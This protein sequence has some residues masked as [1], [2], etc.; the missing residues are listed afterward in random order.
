MNKIPAKL[1]SFRKLNMSK[2]SWLLIVSFSSI[3]LVTF[4]ALTFISVQI[5]T[6]QAQINEIVTSNNKKSRLVVEM[7]QSARDRSL[8]LYSM[9]SAKG[10]FD[11]DAFY[12]NYKHQAALFTKARQEFLSM[13]LSKK[14]RELIKHQGK[15]SRL[16]LPQQNI[17]IKLLHKRRF[18]DA[19]KRLIKKSI[20]AQNAVLTQLTKIIDYQNDNNEKIVAQL[21]NK[22][23]ESIIIIV[24]MSVIIL[25]L[26]ILTALYVIT[27]ITRTEELLYFEKELAQ[28]TL[29][30][31]GDGVITVNKDYIIQTINPV[32]EILTD[33]KK[34]D[35]INKNILSIYDGESPKQRS[36]INQNLEKTSLQP[37]LFDFT[38]TKK[39]GTKFE[40]EHTIA[41]II[42]NNKNIL[43]AVIILRDVTE[44]RTMEKRLSYQ[45]SHD[46]LT[47]LINRREFEVRLKQTIRN[48]LTE[49]LTHSICFLDLDKFKIINDTSG[50]AAGDEFLKQVSKTIQS[51]LRQTDVLARLGGDEFA[52]ILDSCSIHQAKNICNQ[53]IKKIKDTRFNW[54]KNSFEAGASIGIVPIT[55]LTASVSEVMSSVD[56]ACYE[57]KDKGRNRVQVFEPNDAEFVKHQLETSWIQKIKTA[58]DENQFE[59]YFQE[60]RNIN[61]THP[62]PTSIELLIRL[63]DNGNI[64]CPDSFIPTAERYSLMPMIDEWVIN[65]T[66]DFIN[67]YNKKHDSDIRVAI[68]LSGQSLSEDSVLNLITKLLR[69]NKHLKKELICFEITETAAIANMSKAIEFIAQIKQI[70]CK[71]SLDDFGS[72]LSSFSY[73]KSMAV[74]NIKIDGVFIRDIHI[75][76]INKIFVESIHNISKIMGIRTTAEYVENE[77]ILNCIKSIGIDYAQGYHISKP[78]SIK[79]LL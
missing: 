77:E 10:S 17:I 16:A 7:Q 1:I 76:P 3:L 49:D 72:G 47:G 20:P 25:L 55:K 54:G 24:T 79:K 59:L 41:P 63:N 27:R 56:A 33:V 51:L 2:S 32:A 60:L 35:V 58:I 40:V 14:E 23:E 57:A 37:F 62:T 8:A 45:A 70:G 4:F 69:K 75:D 67:E 36:E 19:A 44:V 31:I 73:L 61:P 66:F 68:N 28:I 64:I 9:V 30:S 71:F 74:D 13:P 6:T 39:D 22:V 21:Q 11:Y 26:T 5:K 15:L 65:N 38:L 50:H 53:I 42:D 78:V 52:I 43:G 34:H 46:A 12:S 48:A 18:D 29:H